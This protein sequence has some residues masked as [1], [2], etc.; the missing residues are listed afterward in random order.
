MVKIFLFSKMSNHNVSNILSI[1]DRVGKKLGKH[2]LR[3]TDPIGS[4]KLDIS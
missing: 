2:F 1:L 3:N 4:K